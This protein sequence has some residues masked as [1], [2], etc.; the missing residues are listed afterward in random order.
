[1]TSAIRLLELS[2]TTAIVDTS[3][4]LKGVVWLLSVHVMEGTGIPVE[5]QEIFN[6]CYHTGKSI[7]C[8]PLCRDDNDDEVECIHNYNY[9]L[10]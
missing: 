9:R 10:H 5:L 3:V 8:K 2:L 1:M 6:N 7:A 4:W